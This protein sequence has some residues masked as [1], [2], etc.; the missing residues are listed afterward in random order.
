MAI[1]FNAV[2]GEDKFMLRAAKI[3]SFLSY[4]DSFI[5]TQPFE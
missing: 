1:L 3:P 4:E 2:W 5:Q